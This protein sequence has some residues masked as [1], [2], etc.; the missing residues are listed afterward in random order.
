MKLA[1]YHNLPSGGARRAFQE[2]CSRLAVKHT[3]D[4]FTPATSDETFLSSAEFANKVTALPLGPRRPVRMGLYLNDFRRLLDLRDLDAVCRQ[5]AEVINAGDYD[6]ALIDACRFTQAPSVLRYLS[7][8]S[9]YYCHEP[10]RRFI[11][12]EARPSA[13]PLTPYE[14]ARS[15]WH[16]PAGKIYDRITSKLDAGNAAAATVILT[17]SQHTR[18]TIGQYY[19]LDARLA[20]LGVDSDRFHPTA[21]VGDYVLSVGTF[22]AHKG[23]DFLVRAMARCPNPRPRLVLVGN[24]DSARV[25]VQLHSQA[26][27]LGVELETLVGID[28]ERLVS[29]YQEAAAFL[30]APHKE[31]FGLVILEAMACGIPVIAVSEGGPLESVVDG[32]T[33]FLVPRD[34]DAFAEAI[35]RVISDRA[36][37]RDLGARARQEALARWSW[38]AAVA[39]IETELLSLIRPVEA[40]A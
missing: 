14:R 13:A 20:Y 19:G 22:E 29:L 38:D 36:L 21:S 15:W 1:V 6:V 33:G 23:F 10:P 27:A 4:V 8:P 18:A 11:H 31:P 28:H 26:R 39:A 12:K 3:L 30:Y 40:A 5:V 17:N 9:V 35:R 32:V 7:L 37:A 34:E 2:V 16:W 25:T 24:E